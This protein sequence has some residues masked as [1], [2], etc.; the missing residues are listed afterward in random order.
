VAQQWQKVSEHYFQMLI[1]SE[2]DNDFHIERLFLNLDKF[3]LVKYS[4]KFEKKTSKSLSHKF[5]CQMPNSLL[6]SGVIPSTPNMVEMRL[7]S[8]SIWIQSFIQSQSSI[9]IANTELILVS[10]ICLN[11]L[12]RSIKENLWFL[13]RLESVL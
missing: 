6:S 4:K 5:Q 2:S 11:L 8:S 3:T 7:P 1:M 10:I 9:T 13:I 12:Q